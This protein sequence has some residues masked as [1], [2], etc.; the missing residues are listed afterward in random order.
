MLAYECSFD[1]VHLYERFSHNVRNYGGGKLGGRG[2]SFV[3]GGSLVV[4]EAN[5]DG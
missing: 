5:V 2:I 3:V 4:D 1:T